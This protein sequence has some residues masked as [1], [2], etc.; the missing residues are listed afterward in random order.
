VRPR[1][2]LVIGCG[3]LARELR[4]VTRD[5]PGVE[6]SLLPALLHNRPEAIP[7]LVR[8]RV[9]AA[10]ASGRYGRV[11][12]AYADCGTGGLLDRVCE[13]EGV[14]RLPGAHCYEVYAGSAVFS[15]LQDEEPGTFYLTD[16]LVRAF[17]ALVWSGLGLDRHP[18]LRDVYFANYRRVVYL[19]QAG[20]PSLVERAREAAGRLGLAFEVRETG[21]EGLRSS[22]ERSFA[23]ADADSQSPSAGRGARPEPPRDRPLSARR[24][25]APEGTPSRARPDAWPGTAVAEAANPDRGALGQDSRVGPDATGAVGSAPWPR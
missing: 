1:S 4:A 19:A 23:A 10:R 5:L 14:E 17:E 16:F 15:S 12:V 25:P 21:L 11:F 9:R 24:H 22:I 7:A 20:D 6:V 3:A 8:E 18:E 13:A 2:V